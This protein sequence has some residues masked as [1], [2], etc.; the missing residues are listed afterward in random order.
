MIYTTYLSTLSM[1]VPI[2]GYVWIEKWSVCKTKPPR[3]S[4][5]TAMQKSQ[6][7][8]ALPSHQPYPVKTSKRKTTRTYFHPAL[9][10]LPSSHFSPNPLRPKGKGHNQPIT[11]P[12][13]P[14]TNRRFFLKSPFNLFSNPSVSFLAP[15]KALSASSTDISG[16]SPTDHICCCCGWDAARTD[17]DVDVGAD[18]YRPWTVVSSS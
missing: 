1:Y 13:A 14:N 2:Y 8:Y 16:R 15:S 9:P 18:V 6:L 5:M 10:H 3:P 17:A 12:P 11:P 7:P 4:L